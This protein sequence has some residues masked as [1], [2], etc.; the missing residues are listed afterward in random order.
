MTK[1]SLKPSSSQLAKGA[2][3]F[4]YSKAPCSMAQEEDEV[5]GW[6]NGAPHT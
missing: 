5:V 4:T 2:L 6:V 1:Q 3:T